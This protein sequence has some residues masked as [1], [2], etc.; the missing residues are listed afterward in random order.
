MRYGEGGAFRQALASHIAAVARASGFSAQRL[1]QR[2]TFDRLLARLVAVDPGRWVL[3]GGLALDFRLGERARTTRDIDL[4]RDDNAAEAEAALRAAAQLDLGDHFVFQVERA[5]V[6]DVD[7]T[8]RVATTRYSVLPRLGAARLNSF[9]LDVAVDPSAL[10]PAPEPITGPGLL[11]FAGIAPVT[12]LVLPLACHIAEKVH[13]YSR[14]YGPRGQA[15]SRDKDLVDLILIQAHGQVLSADLRRALEHVFATRRA[16]PLP[17][18]L[19]MPPVAWRVPYR[20]TAAQL[21]IPPDLDEAFRLAD[22]FV[23][24]I[25]GGTL[26]EGYRW[27]PERGWIAG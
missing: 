4:A 5:G 10:R 26:G 13:A 19:P 22:A 3:K 15:S 9:K 17:A 2:V 20:R 25:L 21:A 7:G 12:V 1:W 6:V 27:I 24:P 14:T 11:T 16:P 18:R 8:G 23:T